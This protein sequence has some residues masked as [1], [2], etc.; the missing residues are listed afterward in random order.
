MP[1]VNKL[2]KTLKTLKPIAK[3]KVKSKSSNKKTAYK[4]YNNQEMFYN[5]S[6]LKSLKRLYNKKLNKKSL[7]KRL[8][9]PDEE[10]R[11]VSNHT[12][13]HGI[14]K[15]V[16]L[17]LSKSKLRSKRLAKKRRSTYL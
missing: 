16:K 6:E 4:P 10:M 1:R 13:T 2:K 5:N 11:A 14:Y 8:Y 9:T 12:R 17:N 7:L 3:K 15:P